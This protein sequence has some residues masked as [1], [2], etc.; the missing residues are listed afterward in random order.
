M[1]LSY[2]VLIFVLFDAIVE[3]HAMDKKQL[4]TDFLIENQNWIF[5]K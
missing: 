2:C 5:D 1:W 3:L 4:F